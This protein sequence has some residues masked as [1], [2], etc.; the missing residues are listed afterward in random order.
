MTGDYAPP[1]VGERIDGMEWVGDAWTAVCP[2][3]DIP[4]TEFDDCARLSCPLCGV[5]Y[6]EQMR[7][8]R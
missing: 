6:L 2:A 1:T 7:G 8:R 3:C 5:S 4:M